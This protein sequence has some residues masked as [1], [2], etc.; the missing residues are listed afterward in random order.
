MLLLGMHP[1]LGLLCWESLHSCGSLRTSLTPEDALQLL[2][3]DCRCL[4]FRQNPAGFD[5]AQVAE[6][7]PGEERARSAV[8]EGLA[9]RHAR[10]L[11]AECLAG[12]PM[13]SP[14]AVRRT[15]LE[16]RHLRQHQL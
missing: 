16:V 13:A 1:P 7:V 6:A 5:A 9:V 15:L 8:L 4:F 12:A 3:L 11:L 10:L 2:Q 14:R